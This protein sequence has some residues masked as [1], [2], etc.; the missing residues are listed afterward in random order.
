MKTARL[1]F[2]LLLIL[3]VS[4]LRGEE[5]FT[6]QLPDN[7]Q[8]VP[9]DI[10]EVYNKAENSLKGQNGKGFC[11]AYERKALLDFSLPYILVEQERHA[12]YSV[13]ELQAMAEEM[14][15]IIRRAYLPLHRAGSYGE[16]KVM[17]GIY[18][19][20]RNMVFTYYEMVRAKP[21]EEMFAFVACFPSKI[22]L[23]RLQGFGKKSDYAASM[24]EME[25]ILQSFS[26]S[27]N[28][29]Y[30]PSAKKSRKHQILPVVCIG[31]F[32]ALCALKFLGRSSGT[33]REP[34]SRKEQA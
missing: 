16:V 29:A 20:E 9:K 28:Y 30:T 32:L 34:F 2:A 24:E 31:A 6:V 17:P 4:S 22:G 18:D 11:A 5:Y 21:R 33:T 19:R 13:P 7:W 8:K 26:F 1:F 10:L 23:I 27:T 14:P 3:S 15:S 25:K 12:P